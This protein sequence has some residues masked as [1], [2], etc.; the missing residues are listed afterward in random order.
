MLCAYGS[1]V[2]ADASRLSVGAP[3]E[4]DEHGPLRWRTPSIFNW[5]FAGMVV[6]LLS[7]AADETRAFR[8]FWLLVGIL[9]A[10]ELW[11]R[12]RLRRGPRLELR[13]DGSARLERDSWREAEFVLPPHEVVGAARRGR[14]RL[15]V[16]T[17]SGRRVHLV[18]RD[19]QDELRIASWVYRHETGEPGSPDDALVGRNAQLPG[20]SS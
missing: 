1:D 4:H 9:V 19:P 3:L 11:Q 17:R 5:C 2:A 12:V 16:V 14:R 18:S 13:T 7:N 8:W 10:V 15:L 20:R 6:G